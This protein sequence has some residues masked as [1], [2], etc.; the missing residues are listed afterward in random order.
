[1]T[2]RINN[3]FHAQNVVEHNKYLPIFFWAPPFSIIHFFLH[4]SEFQ[5]SNVFISES[6]QA[7]CENTHE[8]QYVCVSI[9]LSVCLCVCAYTCVSQE[10]GET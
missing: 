4:L 8:P 10:E 5:Q 7:K 6:Q 2:Q 3:I 1:M 9:C